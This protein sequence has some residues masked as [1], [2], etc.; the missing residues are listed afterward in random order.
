MRQLCHRRDA[1]ARCLHGA[2]GSTKSRRLAALLFGLSLAVVSVGCGDDANKWSGGSPGT[3]HGVH[4]MAS[5]SP[6][7]VGGAETVEELFHRAQAAVDGGDDRALLRCIRPETRDGWLRDLVVATAIES[8][9]Q[10]VDGDLERARRAKLRAVLSHFGASVGARP[11]TLDAISLGSALLAHVE[12][13][14]DLFVEL[15]AVARREG[16]PYDPIRILVP[17]ETPSPTGLPLVR[18]ADRLRSPTTL[19]PLEAI[20]S[21]SASASAG[22]PLG[23]AAASASAAVLVPAPGS[24]SPAAA[25]PVGSGVVFVSTPKEVLP[26][27]IFGAGGLVWLDES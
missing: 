1:A 19:V 18:L 2:K 8:T 10:P 22:K 12:S 26:L 3:A 14:E 11:K 21:P 5:A 20:A 7:V 16:S 4:S 25:S 23:S 24:A 17:G 15:L 27:R 9:D 6:A 13:P